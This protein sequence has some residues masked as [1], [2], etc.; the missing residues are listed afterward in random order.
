MAVLALTATAG[1]LGQLPG[2]AAI[3]V[4]IARATARDNADGTWSVVVHAG[5]DQ[6][7]ALQSLGATVQIL[8]TDAEELAQFEVIDTQIDDSP[9]VA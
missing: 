6:I 5:E 9:P 8:K 3:P 1:V 7:G 4:A 2:N